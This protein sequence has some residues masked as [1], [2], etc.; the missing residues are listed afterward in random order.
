MQGSASAAKSQRSEFVVISGDF[1]GC[2][3]GIYLPYQLFLR[4]ATPSQQFVDYFITQLNTQQTVTS[5]TANEPLKAK[6]NRFLE[7]ARH[8]IHEWMQ[9]CVDDNIENPNSS[10]RTKTTAK[11][12]PLSRDAIYKALCQAYLE[13]NQ[14]TYFL[15]FSEFGK[16]IIETVDSHPCQLMI[17]SAR[18]N[19]SLDFVNRL[20]NWNNFHQCESGS[21]FT[22]IQRL[23][24]ALAGLGLQTSINKTTMEDVWH[25]QKIGTEFDRVCRVN[26][27][28]RYFCTR[29]ELF[30]QNDAHQNKNPTPYFDDS[31]ITLLYMQCHTIAQAH[32]NENVVFHFYDDRP[33]ICYALQ[34]AFSEHPELLPRNV[35]LQI[36]HYDTHNPDSS[37]T[38]ALDDNKPLEHLSCTDGSNIPLN[39]IQGT[40]ELDTN[41][42]QNVKA[43]LINIRWVEQRTPIKVL[44]SKNKEIAAVR[45]RFVR[46]LNLAL[47]NFINPP[48]PA[49]SQAPHYQP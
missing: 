32:P 48:P 15:L 34:T 2:L 20:A 27:G 42:A 5:A 19:L 29:S 13:K 11:K 9:G 22:F 43:L 16:Q 1:D 36:H 21:V 45:E 3:S 6:Q 14:L 26:E 41:L 49:P 33:D 8:T 30:E 31:K 46:N 37:L 4:L 18:Q 28:R 44:K 25:E 17:G 24:E 7:D 35:R 47:N 10:D 12:V 38:R 40:G 39:T 23:N